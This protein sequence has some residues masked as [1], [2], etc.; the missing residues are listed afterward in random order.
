MGINIWDSEYDNKGMV[1]DEEQ[2]LYANISS[3]VSLSFT[4]ATL[5]VHLILRYASSV[6]PPLTLSVILRLAELSPRG[7][8]LLG[9]SLQETKFL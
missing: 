9:K 2:K 4:V 8:L 6:P 3:L 1:G 5:L 7:L